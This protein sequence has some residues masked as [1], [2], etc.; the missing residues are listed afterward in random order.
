MGEGQGPALLPLPCM[1]TK[2]S[3]IGD[4]AADIGSQ[5]AADCGCRPAATAHLELYGGWTLVRVSGFV[6]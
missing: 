3:S 4:F 2:G 1:E 6:T 5:F